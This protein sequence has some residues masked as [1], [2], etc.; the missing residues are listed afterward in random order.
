MSVGSCPEVLNG[1]A[2]NTRVGRL[3]MLKSPMS[4]ISASVVAPESRQPREPAA[5]PASAGSLAMPVCRLV[6]TTTATTT[7]AKATRAIG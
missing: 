5:L 1:H 6:L 7:I 2:P 3:W 4:G